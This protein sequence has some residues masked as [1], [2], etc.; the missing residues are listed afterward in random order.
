MANANDPLG[1][2]AERI[3]L[4]ALQVINSAAITAWTGDSNGLRDLQ[5]KNSEAGFRLNN[6]LSTSANV[7]VGMAGTAYA[8][9][10]L[11][12]MST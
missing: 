5:M 3:Q 12:K 7:L 9:F 11:E 4:N 6:L 10:G 2:A 8:G 1:L